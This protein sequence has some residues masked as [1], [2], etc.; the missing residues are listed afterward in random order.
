MA[1]GK[2]SIKRAA[3]ANT[4][5]KSAVQGE[6]NNVNACGNITEVNETVTQQK[7]VENKKNTDKTTITIEKPVNTV[8]GNISPEVLSSIRCELPI[9]LL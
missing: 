4:A 3:K 8:I 5:Q 7:T 1:V 2:D 9:H 6:I